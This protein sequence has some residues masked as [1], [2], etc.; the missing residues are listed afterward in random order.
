V[1]EKPQDPKKVLRQEWV[2]RELAPATRILQQARTVIKE[3]T[4]AG[5]RS[6]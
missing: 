4:S 3:V 5:P 6:R 1:A 2:R